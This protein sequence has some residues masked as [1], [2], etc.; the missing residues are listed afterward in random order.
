MLAIALLVASCS[1]EGETPQPSVT[2]PPSTGAPQPSTTSPPDTKAVPPSSTS[3]PSTNPPPTPSAEPDIKG[4]FVISWDSGRADKVYALMDQGALPHF[5]ALADRGLRAKYARS[6][7]PTLSAAAQNSIST[8]CYPAK[9][10]LVSNSYHNPDDSFY[11][12]R[13]GLDEPLD[14]A[15]PVWVTASRAGFKT[16]ALFF[17]GGS[18]ELPIQMADYTI[19]YGIRDAYSSQ[20]VIDLAPVEEPWDGEP[21]L[22]SA[23]RTRA[24][25]RSARWRACTCTCWIAAMTRSLTTTPWLSILK[26]LSTKPPRTWGSVNGVNCC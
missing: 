4:V 7:D 21:P 1:P 26:G 23:R 12:Y 19:G 6:V 18:P 10:G 22:P 25:T 11:W 24:F 17:M 20:Q 16:A 3:L 15:E 2:F 14:Q 8:G 13:R 5:K 9:T